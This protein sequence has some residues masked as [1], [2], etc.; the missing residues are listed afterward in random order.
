[1]TTQSWLLISTAVLGCLSLYFQRI[2][3]DS[4]RPSSSRRDLSASSFICWVLGVVAIGFYCS[5]K[6]SQFVPLAVGS[7]VGG[8]AMGYVRSSPHGTSRLLGQLN[9]FWLRVLCCF[10][11]FC[12]LDTRDVVELAISDIKRD[13]RGMKEEKRSCWFIHLVV[14]RHTVGTIVPILFDSGVRVLAKLGPV[15]RWLLPK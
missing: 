4:R 2:A 1:M 15:V 8:F 10:K 7:A 13:I 3:K 14:L 11:W 12:C 9:G 6:P 5:H